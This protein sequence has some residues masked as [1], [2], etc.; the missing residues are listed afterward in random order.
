M[1]Q[2]V[3]N[4]LSKYQNLRK[5][6]GNTAWLFAD[7]V[8]RAFAAFLVAAWFARVIGPELFGVY[9]YT[10]AVIVVLSPL[11]MLG[12]DEILIRDLIQSPEKR[13][14]LLGS[15][16][17]L[18]L[19]GALILIVLSL[20][21][22]LTLHGND[23]LALTLFLIFG[24][25]TLARSME[26]A[27][28]WFQSQVDSR[29]SIIPRTLT[30]LF[31]TALKVWALFSSNPLVYFA[32]CWSLELFIGGL[33]TLLAYKKKVGHFSAWRI[34]APVMKELFLQGWPLMLAAALVNLHMRLDQILLKWWSGDFEV[35]IYSGAVRLIE[36]WYFVPVVIAAGLFPSIVRSKAVSEVEYK[37]RIQ[38]LYDLVI[39]LGL[40]FAIAMQVLAP[41]VV[42]M[43]LGDQFEG[44]IPILKIYCWLGLSI[45]FMQARLKWLAV[46]GRL[47]DM[48]WVELI[49]L[50][51]NGLLNFFWI[52]KLGA[53]GAAWAAFVSAI[54]GNILTATFSIPIRES[55]RMY[56]R[57]LILPFRLVK[58]LKERR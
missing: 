6:A 45:F 32:L 2:V 9:N 37:S 41:L 5:V 56:V 36:V 51:V 20:A 22:A 10:F 55:L 12:I 31:A 28:L 27:D 53:I 8:L 23:R 25:G 48:L 39:W 49:T 40:A 43:L 13:D 44:S 7:K 42:R 15:A 21:Y 30:M 18:K 29:S 50:L 26:V 4:H 16:L 3:R 11:V 14:M 34:S 17:G 47:G 1:I 38:A 35:G 57:S 58:L 54:A 46:E 33:F 52:P 19:I 24:I